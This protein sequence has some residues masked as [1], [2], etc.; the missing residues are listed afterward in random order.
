MALFLNFHSKMSLIFLF[1]ATWVKREPNEQEVI[2]PPMVILSKT[3]NNKLTH[4]FTHLLDWDRDETISECDFDAL[5]EVLQ[6]NFVF[7]KMF[8]EI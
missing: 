4:F 7:L 3:Q 6:H 8:I 1:S 2:P 5:S